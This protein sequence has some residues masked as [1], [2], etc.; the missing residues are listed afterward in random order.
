MSEDALLNRRKDAALQFLKKDFYGSLF[1]IIGAVAL[2]LGIGSYAG[3]VPLT[4]S[5]FIVLAI[6][7]G[8]SA[9]CFY[10]K[11][12]LFAPW[13]L[14]AWIMWVSTFI[15]TRNLNGLKDVTTGTWT[16]GPDL[17]PFLF[18]RW[19]KYIV[20]QGALMAVDMFRYIPL[21]YET[22]R[23]VILFPYLIAGFH[24]A[25]QTI[26]LSDSVTYSAVI[27]PVFMFALSI[28]AFFLM[29]RYAF[30][31]T[32]SEQLA[33]GCA[34]VATFFYAILP[35]LLPRTIAG[36][37]EKESA[38][39]VFLFLGIYLF[40]CGWDSPRLRNK[41]V[42]GVAGGL[43]AAIMAH[44]WGGYIYLIVALGGSS[45]IAL[46]LGQMNKERYYLFTA[47]LLT[48]T[49][50]FAPLTE[51]TTL[52][53]LMTSLT[54]GIAFL[55]FLVATLYYLSGFPSLSR[56]IEHSKL[57]TIP[58]PVIALGA[59][60]VL[61]II[62]GTALLGP[63]FI[64]D[65]LETIY[66][67]LIRPITD[68]LNTTVAE[69]RQPYL[70]EIIQGFGPALNGVYFIF[71]F[72]MFG[73]IM[74]FWRAISHFDKKQKHWL[75]LGYIAF[76]L[77]FIFTRYD[78][79][80]L[81]N[82][83]NAISAIAYFGG[84]ALF[85]GI[86]AYTY[87]MCFRERKTE[88]FEKVE[89]ALVVMIVLFA[90]SFLSARSAVR[91]I[92]MLVPSA[93]L[94]M[95]FA[96]FWAVDWYKSQR[97][98]ES[99]SSTAALIV[100]GLLVLGSLAAAY[101]SYQSSIGAA[102]SYVPS[103][104]THQWQKAMDWVRKNTDS[105]SVFMHWWDYGYWVQSIGERATVLDGGNAIPYWNHLF[106]RK[107]LTSSSFEDALQWGKTHKTTH[108]LIDST[109][110]GKY[111]AFSSIGSNYS[112]DRR[113]WINAFLMDP[114]QTVESKNTTKFAYFGSFGLDQDILYTHQGQ[115]VFIPGFTDEGGQSP[116]GGLGAVIIEKAQDGTYLQP[117]GVFVY[118]NKQYSLPLRYLV[119][120]NKSI[121]FESGL[122]A[123]VFIM[124]S[125]QQT[126]QGVSLQ[127]DGALIYLSSAT[128]HTLF[129]RLYLYGEEPQ[130]FK[131]VHNQPDYVVEA[132]RTQ[133]IPLE[134]FVYFQGVRGPIK[135]WE[136]SYS[137]NVQSNPAWLET[138]APPNALF[139]S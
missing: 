36:I 70:T 52:I 97:T 118:Q 111:T 82:G 100:M 132:L 49:A 86:F 61:A 73:S 43:C 102:S 108:L 67:T 106:A 98:R 34:L 120:S 134:D 58:R 69:N 57:R 137:S 9:A 65:K 72:F 37:P 39:F 12:K 74:L 3:F 30:R 138:S 131:L 16:L 35:S 105:T 135:I 19:A 136:V 13:P 48:F 25:L 88:S 62:A 85:I 17:D 47:W 128:V 8:A 109:D 83:Q 78:G 22:G 41:L 33:N 125:L 24:T 89:F 129:A 11:K 119:T 115:T 4:G 87:Y 79:A 64:I 76:I 50:L 53:Q 38:A 113:S 121:D 40:M 93:A 122:D 112:Y 32:F 68:R 21:G 123:G 6:A 55:T 103:S 110:I 2:L 1:L 60:L 96:L 104:Y 84:I 10:F 51:R 20:E 66:S 29:G 75:F 101:V 133:G 126:A 127:A 77:G 54:T 63:S 94:F 26:G 27:F 23:E 18:L 81:F 45:F 80:S 130:G 116:T 95:S 42:Y 107:V 14:V 91:F 117:Q 56:V 44:V 114:S 7:C 31:K 46:L 99:T 5:V 92:M 28:P 139:T 90:A 71:W 15:R 59:G 124:P